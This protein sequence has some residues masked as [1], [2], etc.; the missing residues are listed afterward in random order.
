MGRKIALGA[1]LI[2][3][4]GAIAGVGFAD[5]LLVRES[6]PA[7]ASS[8]FTTEPVAKGVGQVSSCSALGYTAQGF[9]PQSEGPYTFT[10]DL[11]VTFKIDLAACTEQYGEDFWVEVALSFSEAQGRDL[12]A[13]KRYVSAEGG[14]FS[15][16]AYVVRVKGAETAAVT[17]TFAFG[18]LKTYRAY[19]YKPLR[20]GASLVISATA[21][22][23]GDAS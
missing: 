7:T 11:S 4:C 19:F 14:A 10:A 21:V 8:V 22:G 23:Q 3:A 13:E 9:M 2:V 1:A 20:N 5:W 18:D 16:S 17:Y 15:E 6:D 12:F